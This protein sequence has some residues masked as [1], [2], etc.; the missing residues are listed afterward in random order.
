MK[1]KQKLLELSKFTADYTERIIKK[2]L[3]DENE[4]EY[5]I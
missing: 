1:K 4:E 5:N 2:I 3:K